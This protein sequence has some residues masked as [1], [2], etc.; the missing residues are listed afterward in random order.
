MVLAGCG[1]DG[2]VS[3]SGGGAPSIGNRTT[4]NAYVDDLVAVG[5]Y[6]YVDNDYKTTA[7]GSIPSSSSATYRG[8]VG[9]DNYLSGTYAGSVAGDLEMVADY[10]GNGL[11]GRIDNVVDSADERYT[12]ALTLSGGTIDRFADP[13]TE[14]QLDGQFNGRLTGPSATYDASLDMV[15]DFE[16]PN[17]EAI[18]IELDGTIDDGF[19][20]YDAEGV[21]IALK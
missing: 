12:G 13:A 1:G 21:G 8:V 16:G 3:N 5:E 18:Y 20:I 17:A 10:A 11:S 14:W 6:L 2:A 4:F 19:Q 7:S 9:T 15:G